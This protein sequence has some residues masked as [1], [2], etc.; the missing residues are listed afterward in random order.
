MP[1]LRLRPGSEVWLVL[2][3][4]GL[5]PWTKRPAPPVDFPLPGEIGVWQEQYED[6]DQGNY[7]CPWQTTQECPRYSRLI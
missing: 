2:L 1:P 5:W 4:L 7:L 6:F 3:V